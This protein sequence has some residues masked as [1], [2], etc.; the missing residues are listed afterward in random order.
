MPEEQEEQVSRRRAPRKR[1]ASDP[2]QE[3]VEESPQPR[4]QRAEETL[5]NFTRRVSEWVNVATLQAMAVYA[6]AREEVED[7]Y[8]E[9]QDIR[10]RRRS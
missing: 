2:V 8:A 6:R 1:A 5:D 9:A 7:I 4:F 10:Q 3:P